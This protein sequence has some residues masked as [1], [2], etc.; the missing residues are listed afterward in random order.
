[1]N[2][3]EFKS[4]TVI[5]EQVAAL[6]MLRAAGVQ[7]IRDISAGGQTPFCPGTG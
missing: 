4:D 1:M 2:F 6:E 3:N 5:L 7:H